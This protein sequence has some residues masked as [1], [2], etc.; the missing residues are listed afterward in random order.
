MGRRTRHEPGTFSWTD[1]GTTDPEAAKRFYAELL[2][3]SF[4]DQDAGGGNVY[5]EAS[6]EGDA[7]AGLYSQPEQQRAQGVPP[8]WF[9]YVTVASA[10]A[11]AERAAELGAEVHA[12]PFDVVE[13]GRMAVIADPT[14]AMIGVWEPRQSI[15]ARRVNDPGCMTWNELTTGDPGRAIDFYGAL[16]GWRFEPLDTGG[17]PPY[18][19]IAHAGAAGGRNGSMRELALEDAERGMRP[20]WLTYFTVADADAAVERGAAAGGTVLVPAF[21]I[22]TGRIAILADP[23]GAAFGLFAGDVDD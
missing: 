8:F 11:A 15:G 12:G 6:I 3:W 1:L 22:P 9:S 18:W 13:A 14:G 17:G 19:S 4:E 5:V 7:V 23:Q 10:D 21:E 20:A 2:G 16:F